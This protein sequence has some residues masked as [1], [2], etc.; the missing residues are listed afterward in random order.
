LNFL[1]LVPPAL[2]A[3]LFGWRLANSSDKEPNFRKLIFLTFSI[4]GYEILLV[5]TL[6]AIGA[7]LNFLPANF[8]TAL[9]FAYPIVM[10]PV[11]SFFLG[12]L[13]V[14]SAVVFKVLIPK[15]KAAKPSIA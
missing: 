7:M 4:V 14:I 1:Q 15:H 6:L 12:L 3:F 5:Y 9:W 8:P 11:L 13:H 10:F 2:V